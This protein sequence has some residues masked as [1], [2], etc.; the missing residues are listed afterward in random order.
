MEK[1]YQRKKKL[2]AS[3]VIQENLSANS[4]SSSNCSESINKAKLLLH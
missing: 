1:I 4:C 3:N 2:Q